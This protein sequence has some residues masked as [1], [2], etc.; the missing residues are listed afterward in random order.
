MFRS[1]ACCAALVTGLLFS[2]GLSA[3]SANA[4]DG[5]ACA[6]AS[7]AKPLDLMKFMHGKS[8]AQRIGTA[9]AAK[10]RHVARTRHTQDTSA[11]QAEPA[12]VATAFAPET[13]SEAAEPDVQVVASDELNEIDRAAAPLQAA[14]NG[15]VQAETNGA[16][17]GIDP[18]VRT[19]DAEQFNDIDR[20]PEALPAA[21]A[22]QQTNDGARGAASM[23][24][25]EH[26][27]SS[28]SSWVWASL[29]AT[30]TA[31]RHLFG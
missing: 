9:H 29:S 22:D 24:W 5:A 28:W 20:K 31:V 7:A 16:A 18:A 10:A 3:R 6:T 13:T 8:S 21:S 1:I 30:V 12:P 23:S 15:L 11:S 2:P 27:W 4:C 25:L 17:S 26:V 19:V 14:T